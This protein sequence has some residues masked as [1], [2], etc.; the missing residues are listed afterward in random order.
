MHRTTKKIDLL[1][2]NLMKHS[3]RV[4]AFTTS[5]HGGVSDGDFGSFNLS[6]TSGDNAQN[7]TTNRTLLCRELGIDTHQLI[8]SHQTHSDKIA[9]VDAQLLSATP[10]HRITLMDGADALITNMRGICIGVTTADCV[11][12]LLYDPTN[13]ATAAI[14]AGWR[15][16]VANI[17][18]KSVAAMQKQ[19]DTNP[20][21]VISAIGPCIG[22]S[23]FEV[24]EE[25]ADEFMIKNF[26]SCITGGFNKPHIDLTGAICLDLQ[27]AG[28]LP[29]KTE[30][31]GICT[32]TQHHNYFSARRLGIR[33]GR[34]LTGILL[35]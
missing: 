3:C 2:Y 10:E 7:V 9:V 15:G 24:G 11:P 35:K 8:L 29:N 22:T 21:E 12:V 4:E 18:S 20:Q 16:A 1:R 19:Y 6:D 33:S 31:S 27:R 32:Y 13:G 25:V 23:C 28:C 5:R 26:G 30:L 14:H 17:V 34:I